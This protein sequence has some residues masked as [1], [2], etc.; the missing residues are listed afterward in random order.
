[1][2]AG[3]WGY[4]S[5]KAIKETTKRTLSGPLL[6]NTPFSSLNA[7]LAK[8]TVRSTIVRHAP[9]AMYG[10]MAGGALGAYDGANNPYSSTVGGAMYGGVTGAL[11]GAA[12]GFGGGMAFRRMRSLGRLHRLYSNETAGPAMQSR[13]GR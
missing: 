8:P 5:R 3:P 13:L 9:A 1:M 7:W 4:L 11:K 6:S 12:L 10:G 2:P